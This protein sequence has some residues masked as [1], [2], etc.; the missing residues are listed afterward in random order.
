MKKGSALLILL[1]ITVNLFSNNLVDSLNNQLKTTTSNIS[2]IYIFY[3]LIRAYHGSDEKKA[4]ECLEKAKE[5]LETTD[6]KAKAYYY[7]SEGLLKANN[8]APEALVSLKKALTLFSDFKEE[9]GY[10]STITDMGSI[11]IK[12]SQFAKAMSQYLTALKLSQ[13]KND[14]DKLG[15]CYNGIADIYLAQNKPKEAL[16]YHKKALGFYSKFAE[17]AHVYLCMAIEY[18]KINENSTALLYTDSILNNADQL[19]NI[20]LLARTYLNEGQIYKTLNKP[21]K[22]KH[23]F[24]LTYQLASNVKDYE[25]QILASTCMA[26]LFCDLHQP[27]SAISVLKKNMSILNLLKSKILY[28]HKEYYYNLFLAYDL[29]GETK[30]ALAYYKTF[31]WISDSLM[32]EESKQR[33]Y[34]L[35]TSFEVDKKDAEIGSLNKDNK[36]KAY[37]LSRQRLILILILVS[38]IL[39]LAFA[40]VFFN[41]FRL[42][43]KL[44]AMLES[45]NI[46]NEQQHQKIL[47]MNDILEK[48]NES[49]L[50]MDNIKS[51]FF[52]NISH[53]FRTPLTLIIGPLTTLYEETKDQEA[54]SV[55][56]HILNQAKRLLVLINQLLDLS[57]L[58]SAKP[59]LRLSYDN[60]NTFLNTLCGSF[61]SYAA[62]LGIDLQYH[63]AQAPLMA[64]FDKENLQKIL[65]NLISNALKHTPCNGFVDISITNIFEN[66]NFIEIT[67]CDNGMGIES[68]EIKNIFEPFYQSTATVYRNIEGS[69]VGLAL[70]KELVELHGGTIDVTS[71]VGKGSSFK[72]CIAINKEMFPSALIMENEE[73]QMINHDIDVVVQRKNYT[74]RVNNTKNNTTILVVE[75]NNDMRDY[76]TKSLLTNYQIVEAVNGREG[77]DK[78]VDLSPDLIITDVMMPD[79]NGYKMTQLIKNDSRTSHIP[80]IILT[81]KASEESKM[82]GLESAAD[83]YIVK[84]FNLKELLLRIKN[85]IHSRQNLR[86][87]FQK[88]ITINPSEVTATSMDEQFLTK[89]LSIVENHM[90]ES[91]FSVDDFCEEIGISKTHAYRKLKA[92]TDQS[93]TEFLRSIRLKRAAALLF[94]KMG[95]LTEIA[96]ATGFTNLSYFS[97][98]FKEQFGVSPSEYLQHNN[99][100]VSS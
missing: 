4:L 70:V 94:K 67:V 59:I 71:E 100:T 25:Y 13:Q 26:G 11:Y 45:K 91:D 77:F 22:A 81:A 54:K 21:D 98:C 23:F 75:D 84:P 14:K 16:K 79:M 1:L 64:W 90:A 83:D 95:N 31:K 20:D 28:L 32:S 17:K 39:S 57:K 15:Y 93:F 61:S 29:K 9:M 3:D 92:L 41:K 89:A 12:Q 38:A 5:I 65:T 44:A 7:Y 66:Q 51:R 86:E 50:E 78:A 87:K 8:D 88:C 36:L 30:P 40:L 68:Q 80:V 74:K 85:T 96:Y 69:G 62:E 46:E 27:D 73:N 33:L 35:Q 76:I 97:R 24:V 58:Q 56:S 55:F 72:F 43:R 18:R 82:E 19:N 37:Q 47:V 63:S 60:I 99:K 53:E 48:Q 2:R 10:F 42:K 49:L 52:T 6:A 34:E